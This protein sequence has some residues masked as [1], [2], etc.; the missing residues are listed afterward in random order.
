MLGLQA[1][2]RIIGSWKAEGINRKLY[3][4]KEEL[5][6]AAAVVSGSPQLGLA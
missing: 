6:K 3:L 2:K 1:S 5:T 4:Y